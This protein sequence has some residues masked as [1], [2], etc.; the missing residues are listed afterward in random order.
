MILQF[1][2]RHLS[3]ESRR[4][5]GVVA[6]D[7][8]RPADPRVPRDGDAEAVL[9]H[10]VEACY[11]KIAEFDLCSGW[12]LKRLACAKKVLSNE[13]AIVAVTFPAE[14]RVP[15]A[16]TVFPGCQTTIR[17]TLSM[18]TFADFS[19]TNDIFPLCTAFLKV[20]SKILQ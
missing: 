13:D 8:Q 6:D 10:L 15:G 17:Q 4:T 12:Q 19:Q 7:V 11:G 18:V 16:V 5:V 3:S 20:R 9:I 1:S 14:R 2:E